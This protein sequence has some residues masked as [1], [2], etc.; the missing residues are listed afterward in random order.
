MPLQTAEATYE[1]AMRDTTLT[2]DERAQ[3]ALFIGLRGWFDPDSG[4]EM[5]R[6]WQEAEKSAPVGCCPLEWKHQQEE[7]RRRT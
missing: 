7:A 1:R 5:F 6:R 3:I 2:R 4:L